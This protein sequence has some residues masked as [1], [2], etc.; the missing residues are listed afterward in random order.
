MANLLSARTISKSFSTR[1]L[2]QGVTLHLEEGERLGIIGPNGAGKSTLLKI[3]AGME[4][5]DDGEITKKRGLRL[6]YVPQE[7]KFPAEETPLQAVVASI[8]G[9]PIEAEVAASIALSKLGFEQFDQPFGEL[10]GGWQ[11]RVAM[12][13]GLVHDPEVMLLDEPTNHL[14]LEAVEWLENFVLNANMSM[15]FVTHDR[16]FLENCAS[17]ILELAP[18]Y[19]DGAFEVSGNYTEFV[20]RKEAF[21]VSQEAEESALAN[22][23]RRDTAWLRQGIQGRQTR[24]KTQVRDAA[25]RRAELKSVS[26][27]NLSPAKRAGIN[28]DAVG[29]KTNKL[30]VM[31]SVAKSMGNNFLFG[32]LDL[33][34][35][36]GRRIGLVGPNG[37]GKTTLLRLINGELDPDS[38][39][40]KR[41][42]NLRVVTASQHRLILDPNMTLQDTLCPVGEMVEYMGREIHVSGWADRFL[43]TREQ[44]GTL[45]GSLSGG[46]QARI[47]IASLMLQPAD[48]LLL[49]EPTN[50]LDIPTLEVL[51][52]ALL[53][54]PGAI[55]LITHDR[56]MLDRI[57]TEYLALDGQ[58]HAKEFAGFEMWQEWHLHKISSK[59]KKTTSEAVKSRQK[60]TPV[61]LSY[62]L[63]REFDGMEQAIA[64]AEAEVER[65]EAIAND[66]NVMVDHKKHS[67]A[68]A[69]VASAHERVRELYNRWAE[70]EGMQ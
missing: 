60:S 59:S 18:S 69:D 6:W 35:T 46:E 39:T 37:S 15:L 21:L 3:L 64:E 5:T 42:D 45:V 65:T 31:H 70:L 22:K 68:C 63:Q 56:F 54:F 23:V 27:R 11:K 9:D 19:P 36:P 58:G 2:F 10:S 17:R 55:L 61:K 51:E 24:N 8:G 30:L 50:D 44:L 53:D 48:I 14:D 29:R 32:D 38:G 47:Q 33:E 34:L 26:A 62:N 16:R 43:F 13:C 40:I 7:S 28:F 1:H 25:S 12:A 20:R 52:E 67:L 66:E 41:A 4:T 57:A 49:D